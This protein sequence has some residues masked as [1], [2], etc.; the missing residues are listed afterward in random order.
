MIAAM[1]AIKEL[2]AP[3]PAPLSL[4]RGIGMNLVNHAGPV[5]NK[6]ITQAL[7]IKDNLPSMAYKVE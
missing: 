2:F 5:K 7:G 4:L 1:A 3:K 6:L